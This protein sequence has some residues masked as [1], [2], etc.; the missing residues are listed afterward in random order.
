MG[1][2]VELLPAV[3][4]RYGPIMLIIR[5]RK[6]N[7][8]ACRN[9]GRSHHT[10]KQRVEVRAVAT[11]GRAGPDRITVAPAGAG[12]VVAHRGDDVLVDCSPFLHRTLNSPLLFS[13]YPPHP[14]LK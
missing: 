10:D 8:E 13:S 12:L 14:P 4:S 9:S 6:T 3:I 11:L 2:D 7:F 1:C 5:Q